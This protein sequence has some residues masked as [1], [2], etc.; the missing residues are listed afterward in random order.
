MDADRST[1]ALARIEAALA[2]IEAASR[3]PA[4]GADA[5]ELANLQARH[6]RLRSVVGESLQQLDQLIEA[7]QS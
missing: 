6:E 1:R 2:R 4:V 7:T 3:R 5:D